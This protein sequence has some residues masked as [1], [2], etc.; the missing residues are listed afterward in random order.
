MWSLL[1]EN[2]VPV[3]FAAATPLI[4]AF[5]SKVIKALAKRWDMEQL[6]EYDDKVQD[7]VLI[8]IRAMEKLALNR[9][10]AE[11]PKIPGEEKLGSVVEFVSNQLVLNGLP[12]M[13][14]DAL[15]MMIESSLLEY[16][17]E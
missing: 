8:G 11:L 12:R 4:L 2:L 17:G 13:G 16:E 6:R 7:L 15:K 3:V 10:K 5:S 14:A 1:L 9:V